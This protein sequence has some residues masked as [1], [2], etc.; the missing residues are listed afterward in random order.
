MMN[1]EHILPLPG[2]TRMHSRFSKEGQKIG[3]LF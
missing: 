2:L 3:K 1:F